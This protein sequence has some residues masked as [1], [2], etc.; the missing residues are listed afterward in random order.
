MISRGTTKQDLFFFPHRPAVK[1]SIQLDSSFRS[2]ALAAAVALKGESA[3]AVLKTSV[4][5][6]EK[7]S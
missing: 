7:Y 4:H 1:L 2:R 3:G 6:E 5:T